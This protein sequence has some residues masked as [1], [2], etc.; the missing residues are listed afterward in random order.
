MK[1]RFK[2]DADWKEALRLLGDCNH[3]VEA[4]IRRYIEEDR[5]PDIRDINYYYDGFIPVWVLIK[6]RIDQRKE[7]NARARQRR[8]ERREAIERAAAEKIRR[9]EA[10]ARRKAEAERQARLAEEAEAQRIIDER[11]ARKREARRLKAAPRR[12]TV[13]SVNTSPT[14]RKSASTFASRFRGPCPIPLHEK[15]R[16]E[17]TEITEFSRVPQN[18][19]GRAAL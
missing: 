11:K 5:E 1:P 6:A 14:P 19:T 3:R 18:L 2:F 16:T 8:R 12:S 13:Q 17:S 4:E 7:R 9:R 15:S 10:A